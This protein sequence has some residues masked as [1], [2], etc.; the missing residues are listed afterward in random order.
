M[1]FLKDFF[2]KID[3]ERKIS[4]RQKFMKY[5]PG[6]KELTHFVLIDF[7]IHIDTIS[8]ELSIMYFKGLS[9]N[10]SMNFHP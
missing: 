3:F 2:K 1:I 4:R 7:S 5:F 6:G 9:V 10:F 8:M